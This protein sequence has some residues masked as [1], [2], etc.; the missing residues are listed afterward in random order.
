MKKYILV[1][2]GCLIQAFAIACI[3]KPN[4]LVVAGITGWAIVMEH[5]IG[6]SYV[7]IYYFT[8]L[9][10]LGAAYI[11]LGPKAARR[12]VLLS[13]TYPLILIGANQV[14][15]NFIEPG[16][17]KIVICIFYGVFMGL[18][19]GLVLREGFTQ[20]SSDTL[21]KVL[22]RLIGR[23]FSLPQMM[24]AL[25]CSILLLSLTVFSKTTILYAL[26]IQFTYSRV[27]SFVLFGGNMR[28]VKMVIISKYLK[29]IK[30][31]FHEE[32][33]LNYSIDYVA[34]RHGEMMEKII[35]VCPLRDAVHA[36]EIALKIDPHAFIN[37]VP[38]VE[39]WGKDS[40]LQKNDEP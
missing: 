37:F 8:C 30:E 13:V 23:G 34:N 35:S 17:E 36:R 22:H 15:F 3:L 6:I 20:G 19:T 18:G 14:S 2:L 11:W 40:F 28:I 4:D 10:I 5:W 1:Y 33:E 12:I 29:E 26:I 25:D 9:L 16:T 27:V 24:L 21:A 31:S 38:T 32:L 39:A 7:Y